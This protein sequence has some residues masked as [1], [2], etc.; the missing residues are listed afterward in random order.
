MTSIAEWLG[1][2]FL[3]AAPPDFLFFF[4]YYFHGTNASYQMRRIA[5]WL[6]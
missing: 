1:A 5:K 4:N 6:L 2:G 3:A